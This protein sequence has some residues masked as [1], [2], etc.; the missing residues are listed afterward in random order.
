MTI[1][2]TIILLIYIM[3]FKNLANWFNK[4]LGL[5][6][7]LESK[8]VLYF[9]VFISIVNLYSYA[10]ADEM[11][12]AGIMMIVGFLS[13]FFNKNMIV[14]IFT[15]IAATNLIR[16]GMEQYN[17][18]EGFT[19]DLTQLDALMNHMTD[20]N[21][22]IQTSTEKKT[23]K[24]EPTSSKMDISTLSE[25]DYDKNAKMNDD[26]TKRDVEIDKFIKKLNP[27]GILQKMEMNIDKN[28][29]DLARDK[30][31]LALK[32]TNKIANEEQRNGVENLLKLQ[33][34]LLD[35]VVNISPL[36]EEFKNVVKMLEH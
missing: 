9:L 4:N 11:M 35:Q 7:L 21:S 28:Q 23:T 3:V 25:P 12:Y 34:K 33:V 31:D 26:P 8:I 16:F 14:I 19:G 18:I 30:I 36:M 24:E 2:E 5:S 13:S 20:D 17:N 27:A 22:P 1:C 15:A 32:H 29:V 6:T 10:M